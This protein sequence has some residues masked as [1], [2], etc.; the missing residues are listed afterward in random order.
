V[1]S[2]ILDFVESFVGRAAVGQT[3]NKLLVG[4]VML[5]IYVCSLDMGGCQKY[6]CTYVGRDES[7]ERNAPNLCLEGFDVIQKG[8]THRFCYESCQIGTRRTAD[9][10]SCCEKR[11]S[12]ARGWRHV[13]QKKNGIKSKE[14]RD[15][16]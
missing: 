12:L 13:R 3:Q 9:V 8:S 5:C 15:N 14:Q 6:V 11:C 4:G 16:A 2:S 7:R 10:A 1:Q